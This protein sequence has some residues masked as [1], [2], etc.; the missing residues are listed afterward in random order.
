[1]P[2][3]GA[4]LRSQRKRAWI[5]IAIVSFVAASIEPS[6]LGLVSEGNIDVRRWM[7]L[8]PLYALP[9]V[10][11]AISTEVRNLLRGPYA[12]L[13]ASSVVTLVVAPFGASAPGDVLLAT[14]ALSLAL[15]AAV[16]VER[17]GFTSLVTL[18]G[19]VTFVLCVVSLVEGTEASPGRVA[20][21]Y[22]A[23]NAFGVHGALL[24][25][26]GVRRWLS[27]VP[28]R[29]GIRPTPLIPFAFVVLG[30]VVIVESQARVAFVASLVAILALV[31]RALPL[32]LVVTVAAVGLAGTF[33]LGVTGRLDSLPADLSR[34]SDTA[35]LTSVTGRTGIWE[36]SLE[37]IA[38]RP[39][40]GYGF[41][42]NVEALERAFLEGSLEFDAREAHNIVLQAALNGGVLSALL[43]L[44]A[45]LGFVRRVHER[46]SPVAASMVA[47]IAVHG[48]TESVIREPKDLWMLLAAALASASVP[49]RSGVRERLHP[50]Q[51]GGGLDRLG[52]DVVPGRVSRVPTAQP[53]G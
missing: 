8:G 7:L 4:P 16:L 11:A 9:L 44:A 19:D 40:T 23:A 31:Y 15:L 24:M 42:G 14:G 38:E 48:L 41:N 26:E 52:R 35:E 45:L 30:I 47:L 17:L 49:A 6:R 12:L 34:S 22:P 39:L 32:R 25:V 3:G 46:P 20:G 13:I 36:H 43:L 5:A 2:A 29:K 33:A 21:L 10:A 28:S 51:Y 27:A 1:M 18:L 50:G 37:L 53:R